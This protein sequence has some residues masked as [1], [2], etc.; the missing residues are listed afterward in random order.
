MGTGRSR[1]QGKSASMNKTEQLIFSGLAGAVLMLI[2]CI[3]FDDW[4]SA[5]HAGETLSC[6][7]RP[8]TKAYMARLPGESHSVEAWLQA[9]RFGSPSWVPEMGSPLPPTKGM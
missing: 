7:D 4:K 9:I 8:D 3:G 2:F 5:A 6:R 1:T